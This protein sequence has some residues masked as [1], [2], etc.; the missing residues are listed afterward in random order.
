MNPDES[1]VNP[2]GKHDNANISLYLQLDQS[3]VARAMRNT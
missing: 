2:V 3:A 1:F